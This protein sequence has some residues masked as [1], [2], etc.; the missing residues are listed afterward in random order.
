[1]KNLIQSLS[2]SLSLKLAPTYPVRNSTDGSKYKGQYRTD[3]GDWTLLAGQLVRFGDMFGVV[4]TDHSDNL[5]GADSLPMIRFGLNVYQLDVLL[6]RE[7]TEDS[8]IAR[9]SYVYYVEGDSTVLNPSGSVL[10]IGGVPGI[11][12]SHVN[13]GA[14]TWACGIL[15]E[16]VTSGLAESVHTVDILTLAFPIST[17]ASGEAF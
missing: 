7:A 12:S 5:A 2:P 13:T 8:P 15:L 9:G 6:R 14:V 17:S 3:D 1:M 11:S 16:D 10:F 4:E